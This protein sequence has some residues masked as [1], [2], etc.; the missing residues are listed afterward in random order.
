MR[1]VSGGEDN[2]ERPVA[3]TAA[4]ARLHER[5]R[6]IREEM[7]GADR[8]SRLADDGRWTVRDRI[9]ALCDPMSFTEIGTFARSERDA[10][11]D[12]TPGDGKIGGHAR[13]GG[14]PV[15]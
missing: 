3:T 4:V 15:T 8:V 13:I 1:P 10:D 2:Q 9:N 12:S 6:L 5:R 11:R 7:G 14:R